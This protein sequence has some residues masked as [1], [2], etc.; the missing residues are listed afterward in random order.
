MQKIVLY[1]NNFGRLE[2]VYAHHENPCTLDDF[3]ISHR[4]EQHEPKN[5]RHI[6]IHISLLHSLLVD[7]VQKGDF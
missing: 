1:D 2:C 3:E 7:E 6:E 5:K 4:K